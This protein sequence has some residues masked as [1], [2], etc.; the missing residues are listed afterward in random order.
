MS[1]AKNN[2]AAGQQPEAALKNICKANDSNIPKKWERVLAAL[3]SGK[4]YNR[5]EAERWLNDHCLHTTVSTIQGMGVTI[6]R[7]FEV[8]PGYMGAE[9]HVCRYWL[10][11]GADNFKRAL[12]LLPASQ[13]QGAE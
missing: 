4:S 7:E 11:R 13:R 12:A 6:R 8:V 1:E 9:T 10:D 5:F 2:R 3:V